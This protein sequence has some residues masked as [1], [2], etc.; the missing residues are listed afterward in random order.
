M[1][2][3]IVIEGPDGAGKTTLYDRLKIDLDLIPAPR[4]STSLGGSK[5]GIYGLMM[6][7]LDRPQG[8]IYDRHPIISEMIYAPIL[9]RP[10][11]LRFLELGDRIHEFYQESIVILCTI[12]LEDLIDNIKGTDQLEGVEDN[13]R[14]IYSA[15][16]DVRFHFHYDYTVDSYDELL[17]K[18][19]KKWTS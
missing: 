14:Q 6:E 17:E 10:L 13:I 11:D 4:F 9:G 7:D 5:A 8:E 19:K 18:V 1:K 16:D 3:R 2:R 12:E 15:Y